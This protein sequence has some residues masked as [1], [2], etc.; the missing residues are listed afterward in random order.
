V[1]IG[2]SFGDASLESNGDGS[3]ESTDDVLGKD[4]ALGCGPLR[5]NPGTMV[6]KERDGAVLGHGTFEGTAQPVTEIPG[7]GVTGVGVSVT[8]GQTYACVMT[9][10]PS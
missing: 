3:G 2:A 10:S 6:P 1:S 5:G 9:N 7:G 4:C 8:I